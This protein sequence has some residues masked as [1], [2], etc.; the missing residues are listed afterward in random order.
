LD[1]DEFPALIDRQG[2]NYSKGWGALR[3][4]VLVVRDEFVTRIQ[5][6]SSALTS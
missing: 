1:G 5:H 3:D 4:Q 6:T 2:P